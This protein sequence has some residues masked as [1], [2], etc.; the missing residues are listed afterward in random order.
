ML[1]TAP[2][3]QTS[4]HDLFRR[5][6]VIPAHPLALTEDRKLDERRQRALTR[7]YVEAG[8]GGLAVG[9]HTTQFAI[10]GTGL[11][12]PCSN[13]RRGPPGSSSARWCWWPG[14]PGPPRRPWRRRSW[15]GCTGTT[16]CCS[17]RTATSTRTRSSTG[18]GRWAR[19]CR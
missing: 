6:L 3:A 14:P 10:H 12:P 15:P 5:G 16:W 8:A 11:L 18:P 4:V 13:W 19:C 9:V 1:S 17:A 7:Y 2:E